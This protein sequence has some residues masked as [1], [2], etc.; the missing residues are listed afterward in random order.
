MVGVRRSPAYHLARGAGYALVGAT[1]GASGQGLFRIFTDHPEWTLFVVLGFMIAIALQSVRIWNGTADESFAV[2][3]PRALWR[4]VGP[5]WPARAAR[6]WGPAGYG[7]LSAFVP[8]GWF[9]YFG[10]IAAST[11]SAPMGAMVFLMLWLG[12]VPALLAAA[13][14]WS[15]VRQRFPGDVFR[16]ASAVVLLVVSLVS[17]VPRF[18]A[19]ERSLRMDGTAP[20][21]GFFSASAR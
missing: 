8:C 10:W 1:A 9:A 4:R 11:G 13:A 6:N 12:S 18:G 19:F 15:V 21:C 3:I 2:R 16:K 14:S 7:L 17:L 20:I 5:A